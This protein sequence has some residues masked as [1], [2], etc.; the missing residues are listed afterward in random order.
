MMA[1]HEVLT[2]VKRR[3][4]L[5]EDVFEAGVLRFFIVSFKRFYDEYLLG[6][7]FTIY[8]S[9]NVL[10]IFS[11]PKCDCKSLCLWLEYVFVRWIKT[12]LTLSLALFISAIFERWQVGTRSLLSFLFSLCWGL[13][14]LKCDG[15]CLFLSYC[16]SCFASQIIVCCFWRNS[17]PN[18]K[19]P[20]IDILET[21]ITLNALHSPRSRS[22]FTLRTTKWPV[23]ITFGTH[24]LF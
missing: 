10:L 15:S 6:F 14:R 17:S 5:N 22:W 7:F 18:A 11:L 21:E 16:D 9:L 2:H 19:W 1:W 24:T 20:N 23:I 3:Q 12:S 4:P 13:N 8:W